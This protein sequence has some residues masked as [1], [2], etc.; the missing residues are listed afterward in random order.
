LRADAEL[1]EDLV[2]VVLDRPQTDEQSAGLEGR[3][4]ASLAMMSISTSATFTRELTRHDWPVA[5]AS[6]ARWLH[7]LRA[8]IKRSMSARQGDSKW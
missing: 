4:R 5:D 3:S 8:W 1:D 6:V 7:C 2:Q